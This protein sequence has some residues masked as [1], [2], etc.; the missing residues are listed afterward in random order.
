MLVQSP[1][2]IF[3]ADLAGWER[4]QSAVVRILDF[5]D[6]NTDIQRFSEIVIDEN[7]ELDLDVKPY[8]TYIIFM[9][10]GSVKVEGFEPNFIPGRVLTIHNPNQSSLKIKNQLGE[11]K[12][13]FLLIESVEKNV[14]DN[15][16]IEEL[17]FTQKNKIQMITSNLKSPNFIGIY[18]GRAEEE[19][20]LKHSEKLFGFV[21]NGAFEFQNRLLENRD[22]ILLWELKELEFEA[23]S[24]D[25][26]ILFIE[27][28]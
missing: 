21:I 10:Y 24:N 8:A 11:E 16:Q 14:K 17:D 28:I 12:A 13:D 5:S 4:V 3:R 26:L 7:G 20:K 18:E 9:V 19:Y 2:K 27:F 25:A 1:S 22:G 23:L 15:F 6:Q